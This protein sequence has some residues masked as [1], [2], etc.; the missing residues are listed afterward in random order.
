MFFRQRPECHAVHEAV[1][2]HLLVV[3]WQL[4]NRQPQMI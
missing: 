1:E 2:R 3:L 4:F